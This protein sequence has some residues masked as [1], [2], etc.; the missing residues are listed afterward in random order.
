M[1]AKLSKEQSSQGTMIGSHFERYKNKLQRIDKAV[2]FG[3]ISG[4]I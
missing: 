1:L 3:S 2:C 4:D